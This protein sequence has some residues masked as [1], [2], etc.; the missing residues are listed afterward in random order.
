MS[1]MTSFLSTSGD[2][3]VSLSSAKILECTCTPT[4]TP[5]S[6][7]PEGATSGL[8]GE[9]KKW[10][11]SCMYL[12]KFLV[13]KWKK[14]IWSPL[15]KPNCFKKQVL[16]HHFYLPKGGFHLVAKIISELKSHMI[17][18]KFKCSHWWKL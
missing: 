15:L 18:Y 3:E 17:P 6:S 11:I 9:L 12:Q 16:C 4:F 1:M 5:G 14:Q 7:A 8:A 10:N 13:P 2:C